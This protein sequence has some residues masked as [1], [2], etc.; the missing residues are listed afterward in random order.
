MEPWSEQSE[1]RWCG[2]RGGGGKRVCM[3]GYA[4][5]ICAVGQNMEGEG[6]NGSVSEC[7]QLVRVPIR[8]VHVCYACACACVMYFAK[9]REGG[10]LL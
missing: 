10:P 4:G 1:V 9:G 3:R 2:G 8:P 7:L 6:W 5:G